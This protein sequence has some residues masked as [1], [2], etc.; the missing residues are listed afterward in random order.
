MNIPKMFEGAIAR[1]I[2]ENAE[3]T[4]MPRIRTWQAIDAEGRWS[5]ESDRVFPLIDIR[6]GPP[7]VSSDDGVTC[8]CNVTVL[9]GT[10]KDDDPTHGELS[11]Y[12]EAIQSVLDSL[13]AQ[14]RS[15]VAG[16]ERNSFDAH[17]RDTEPAS[18]V[19]VGGF[20][21]GEPLDP[22]DDEGAQFI[23][24]MFV[25]HFSRSDF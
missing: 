3:L 16:S 25:I 10:H 22:Y 17:I 1:A 21:H 9:V 23:G 15:G 5:T 7:R 19:T 8:L 6:T 4:D 20:E 2:T 18:I 24:M 14:F 12:Y 13:Y 11:R